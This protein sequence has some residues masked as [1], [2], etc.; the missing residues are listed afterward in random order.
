V[1]GISISAT[2][3]TN[4]S[5]EAIFKLRDTVDPSC[6]LAHGNFVWRD[7]PVQRHCALRLSLGRYQRLSYRRPQTAANRRRLRRDELCL[8]RRVRP[9]VVQWT[10]T[11][12]YRSLLPLTQFNTGTFR[13][14]CGLRY[15]S[16]C[17]TFARVAGPSSSHA[18]PSDCVSGR[19]STIGLLSK[20]S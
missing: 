17:R 12:R 15:E 18:T 9:V 5:T 1:N 13:L 7:E 4:E 6:K 16:N 11:R 20:L 19:Y 3:T 2:G 8:F 14:R 10:A